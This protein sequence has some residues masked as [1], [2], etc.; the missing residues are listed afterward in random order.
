MQAKLECEK[1]PPIPVASLNKFGMT[2]AASCSGN[3]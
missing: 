3:C 2:H 1:Y